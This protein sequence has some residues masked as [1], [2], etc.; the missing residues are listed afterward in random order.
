MRATDG[1]YKLIGAKRVNANPSETGLHKSDQH[2]LLIVIKG[3]GEVEAKGYLS[4]LRPCDVLLLLPGTLWHLHVKEQQS[5]EYCSFTFDVYSENDQY[6]LQ[7]GELEAGIYPPI[8]WPEAVQ[9]ACTI[10]SGWQEGEW[11]RMESTIRFQE[12]LLHLWRPVKNEI[13]KDHASAGAISQSKT[14]IDT[15]FGHSLTREKLARMTGMSVAHY[16]RLFKKQVGQSPMEYLNTV[17]IQN[18]GD[19]LLRS[20]ITLREAANRVGYQDE[21]YFSRKFKAATGIPP[22]VY[23][24]KQRMSTQIASIA[25]PYTSHLLALGLTP[26][27]ALVNPSYGPASGLKNVISLGHDQPDIDSLV[28]A[29]PELIISFEQS[30]YAEPDKA[31]LFPHIAPTCTVPF[32][33]DWREHFQMIARAVNRLEIAQQWLAGYEVLAERLRANVREKIG[34]RKVA[35]AQYEKGSFR[36]F[37]SRNLGTVLYNDLQLSRPRQL[38]NVDHSVILTAEQLVE[39]SIDHLI[40]FTSCDALQRTAIHRSL[41]SQVAWKDLKAVQKGHIYEI[42]DS[43]RYS[44][45]TSLAHDLFLRR[46]SELLMSQMSR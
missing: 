4:A 36:L 15:H 17:R 44:C 1:L 11:E 9:R 38:M 13:V 39:C 14:Y 26:Y 6:T 20:E 23:V 30:D 45:Y 3:S 43:S 24:K 35:V 31:S 7:R 41:A 27:A 16:S 29:R 25:H 42:G 2:T 46:S 8:P 5:L 19:L 37:G 22:T 32:E 21:F 12:L 10:C 34:D 33:G 28:Q 18:A 40:L